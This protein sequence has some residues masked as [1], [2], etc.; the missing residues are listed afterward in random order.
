ME[1]N[2]NQEQQNTAA[3]EVKPKSPEEAA[4]AATLKKKST[5]AEKTEKKS[6]G[7]GMVLMVL[8]AVGLLGALGFMV[9]RDTAK[10]KIIQANAVKMEKDS[11]TIAGQLVQ[12]DTLELQLKRMTDKADALALDKDSLLLLVE[13]VQKL[14]DDLRHARGSAAYFR[15]KVDAVQAVVASRQAQIDQLTMQRDSVLVA[16]KTIE[17]EKG[18]L[19]DS[20]YQIR[21]ERNVLQGKIAIASVL[22]AENIVPIAISSKGKEYEG[23]DFKN[24]RLQKLKVSMVLGENKVAAQN[25]KEIDLRVIEPDGTVLFTGTDG[26]SFNTAEGEEKMYTMSQSVLYTGNNQK[27]TFVFEKGSDYKSGKHT[28]EIYGDGYKIGEGSF[29]VK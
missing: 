10:T 4:R 6:S 26:G 12:L 13:N 29:N 28:L 25:S 3:S 9:F 5:K 21:Q 23:P 19:A 22:K 18:S 20:I 8:L 15:R 24:K 1:E 11:L 14:K 16:M 27:I 2:P 7:I 17:E